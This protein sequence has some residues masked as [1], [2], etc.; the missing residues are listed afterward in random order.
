MTRDE[1]DDGRPSRQEL[2]G[3]STPAVRASL[4]TTGDARLAGDCIR[5]LPVA[6]GDAAVE[7]TVEDVTR[8]L[9]AV[10][11]APAHAA[12]AYAGRVVDADP[13]LLDGHDLLETLCAEGPVNDDNYVRSVC[14]VVRGLATAAPALA[15]PRLDG[16]ATLLDREPSGHEGATTVLRTMWHVGFGA[17][18]DGKR[19][20]EHRTGGRVPDPVPGEHDHATALAAHAEPVAAVLDRQYAARVHHTS[21]TVEAATGLLHGIATVEPAAVADDDVF[22]QVVRVLGGH[23][24]PAR[25]WRHALGVLE[26]VLEHDPAAVDPH[27]EA[28]VTGVAR[29]MATATDGDRVSRVA[30]REAAVLVV[31]LE[32]LPG[33][34]VSAAR[35]AGVERAYADLGA[36][37]V[38]PVRAL[39]RPVTDGTVSHPGARGLLLELVA[40]GTERDPERAA[41]VHEAVAAIGDEADHRA[42]RRGVDRVLSALD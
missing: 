17:G 24:R 5:A 19:E 39:L 3:M 2:S 20:R 41:V 37:A 18:T 23:D 12:A 40:V 6:P 36:A 21:T 38:E 10:E 32:T 42:V 27:V 34:T 25:A 14:G 13:A 16:L 22:R 31:L 26:T 8:A 28:L 1:T 33:P 35:W 11:P 30:A 15:V 7:T 9:E 29:S 4:S